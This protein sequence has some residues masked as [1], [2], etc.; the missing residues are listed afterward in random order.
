MKIATMT[1]PLQG[2][3]GFGAPSKIIGIKITPAIANMIRQLGVSE[4]EYIASAERRARGGQDEILGVL[5]KR[6]LGS[7]SEDRATM[8]VF[9]GFREAK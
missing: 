6:V 2:A 4:G 7:D 8:P 1:F 5:G 3:I 9:G